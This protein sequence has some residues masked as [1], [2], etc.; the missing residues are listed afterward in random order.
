MKRLNSVR[1]S[2]AIAAAFILG[3]LGSAEADETAP[4][5]RTIGYVM[6]SMH[7][8]VHQSPDGKVECPHGVNDGPR[9]H[10]KALFPDDGRTRTLRETQI[11]REAEGF[12]PQTTPEPY[13]FREIESKVA[14]GLNLDG[15]VSTNDFT[16]PDGEV[17][18]DNQL[19]RSV[20]CIQSYRAP[21]GDSYYFDDEN[22][23]RQ[24]FNRW[25]FE[26]TEVDSLVNDDNVEITLYRGQNG[27]LKK[28]DGSD[29]LPGGTQ[30]IDNRW[31]KRYVRHLKGKIIDGVLT[32]EGADVT[33]P[34]ATFGL[35][36]DRVMRDMRARLKLLPT[37]A[38]GVIGGY[39]DLE[40][41]YSQTLRSFSTHIHAYGKTSLPSLYRALVRNA[42]GHP[43]PATG[44]N[45]TLSS[46]LDVKMVRVFIVH[47]ERPVAEN[48]RT[49][50][51]SS[52][53]R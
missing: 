4:P 13:P 11:Q 45:T 47:P 39:T 49:E 46:A 22:V 15:E 31:G 25:L 19:Y 1:T 29:I 5:N 44:R 41:F 3:A 34:W 17:G 10:F 27:L 14:W 50:P 32:T 48:L 42:D 43:D 52:T 35:P 21:D 20:G 33:Y 18:I 9:E 6:T 26:L 38:N 8:A 36:T 53:A 24:I 2:T 12:F 7:W 28:A 51:G 37:G 16:S 40:N 23:V 30:V